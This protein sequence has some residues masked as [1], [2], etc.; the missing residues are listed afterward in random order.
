MAATFEDATDV[1]FMDCHKNGTTINGQYC[2]TLQRQ[3][4]KAMKTK[5]VGKPMKNILLHQERPSIHKSLV[6]KDAV[7]DC[8][9]ELVNQPYSLDLA[10]YSVTEYEKSQTWKQYDGII[11][12]EDEVFL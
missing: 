10:P 9:F 11:S 3:S 5:L 6:L 4:R 2:V 7:R 12:T 8:G 1:M